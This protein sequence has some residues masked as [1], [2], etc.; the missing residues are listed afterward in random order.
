MN[1]SVHLSVRVPWHDSGW[2]GR[3]CHDPLGNASCILLKNVGR[4][5]DDRYEAKH[6]GRSLDEVE[7]HRIACV[8]ERGTF[9]SAH[10]YTFNMKHPYAWHK[11]LKGIEATPLTVPAYGVHTIPY[12]W[13]NRDGVND[14][15]SE[16]DVDFDEQ[17]EDQVDKLLFKG[18]W[19]M[20][21]QNQRA[22]ITRF[23]ED[24]TPHESLVFFYAK[25]SPFDG[26]RVEGPLLVGAAQIT[27]K[28]LPGLWRTEGH[29]AFPTH[30]WETSLT[31]SLRPDGTGGIL[32]PVA[33]LAELD[34]RGEDVGEALA[35]APETKGRE[36][37]YVTEHVA[38]DTAIATLERL[39]T[40]ARHCHEL[41][42]DVPEASLAWLDDRIGEL[43]TMRG[44]A[45]GLGA[46]LGAL[47]F[48]HS[49][50]LARAVARQTAADADPW[51][52]LTEAITH[53]GRYPDELDRLIPETHR[54]IWQQ[55][56]AEQLQVLRLLSRFQL[57]T[58][59]AE[60]L[61]QKKIT[62]LEHDELLD[63]PYLAHIW[64][65]DQLVAVSFEVIDRGC[66]PSAAIRHSFPMPEPSAMEDGGDPR[67][68]LAL[69]V[70]VLEEAAADG[71]TVVTME[72]VIAR[73]EARK[74][75]VACPI[76]EELL[77]AC[78]LHPTQLDYDPE[79]PYWP[80]VT[81]TKLEDGSP[82]YKLARLETMAY[83]IRSVIKS[84]HARPYHAVPEDLGTRLDE[85]LPSDVPA[86]DDDAETEKRA[87]A[88]KKAA[89]AELYAAPLSVLNGRAGT[90]KTTLIKALVRREEVANRGV[91]LLAP[92]GKARVQLQNKVDYPAQTIAQFLIGHG[93]YNSDTQTYA[94]S[95]APKAPF[96][97]TVIIDEASM[98]T[99][100]QLGAILDALTPPDRLIL[101]GDPRQLPPIGA[102]RPF[103]DLIHWLKSE[104]NEPHF[105]RVVRGHAE[106]IEL[107]RQKGHIRDD[108]MLAAWFSGDEVP[109]GFDE[110]WEK[111]RSGER[112][113]ALAALP[114]RGS[115]PLE[116]IEQA[117]ADELGVC[118]PDAARHFEV[119]YGGHVDGAYINFPEG[120]DGAA[121]Q[122][123]KWQVLSPTRGH[124]W[125]TVEINRHLKRTFRQREMRRAT[126]PKWQ[127]T[128]PPPLGAEQIVLGDKVLNTQNGRLPKVPWSAGLGYVAN[129]EIG[130]VV[131][132]LGKKGSNPRDTLIEFSSQ[133]GTTYKYAALAEDDPA[134]E[135][136]WAITIHKSQGSEF[137]KVF[138]L[139]PSSARKLSREMLYTALTRQQ[140]QVILLHEGSIDEL[141][142]LTISTGSETA[143]RLTDLFGLPMPR[144]VF[145][146]DGTP[147]GKLDA[148]LI[149]ITGNGTLVRS[150][151]EVIIANILDN[152]VRGHWRYEL[153][154]EIN[155]KT[156]RPDFTIRTP[157]GRTIYWEHLVL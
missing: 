35:W 28:Q 119:S 100:E 133:V 138:V 147:A 61:F 20:H 146:P 126:A 101:V 99:E 89:L 87:R 4:H 36:F 116:V 151:N 117:L 86:D 69:L 5:R 15:L 128:T 16:F 134:L 122:C 42:I 53:R 57:T 22:L 48:P 8:Q 123:E 7:A 81:G 104:A 152:L 47:K 6:A 13:L 79:Q 64:T 94:L 120:K 73:I 91:L 11:A 129:G 143:R 52:T 131:G 2:S 25:H 24:V 92:T 40:A 18:E 54:K 108:L 124:G 38:H 130:V 154:L 3:V 43:W 55:F 80:P 37:A 115:R 31:H 30:M 72:S 78:R 144:E 71:D 45:P 58:E 140:D 114:W 33:E 157:G 1:G 93:R 112:S 107:R 118:G 75:S 137:R 82:S 150:K 113:D 109:P 41:G 26:S 132:R 59:Q 39:F 155:G 74:L 49:K 102:G 34:A 68:V 17:L 10:P 127:R 60:M 142:E 97:G 83:L 105:P 110:V 90:G 14:V 70:T 145:F 9:L 136:A 44:P 111:L 84:Q 125:G 56:T 51:E 139:L 62:D 50:V 46:V 96:T 85:V 149:H 77:L 65:A 67:R 141:L 19:V 88:E 98:L 103:V 153:P 95:Q 29:T 63:N 21:A 27:G 156:L 135:L 66:F 12:F 23:F 106:L 76:S 32:L 121:D 148:R